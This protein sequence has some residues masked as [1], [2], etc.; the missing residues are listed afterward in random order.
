MD[1][2]WLGRSRFLDLLF[3][4][5]DGRVDFVVESWVLAA[6]VVVIFCRE[7][8][9]CRIYT[10]DCGLDFVAVWLVSVLCAFTNV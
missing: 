2:G 5:G 8:R 3:T 10:G 4:N 7:N 9:A 6:Q 1:T